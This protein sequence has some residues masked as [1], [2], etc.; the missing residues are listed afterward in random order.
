MKSTPVVLIVLT[1]LFLASAAAQ[2]QPS[3]LLWEIGKSDNNNAEFALA[4]NGY[5]RFA[6]GGFFVVGSSDSKLDWPYVHPGPADRLWS[7]AD[8]HT[9]L[10]VFGLKSVPQDGQCKLRLD[11]LDTHKLDPPTMRIEINGKRFEHKMPPGTGDPTVFGD[12]K[13]GKEHKFDVNFPAGLLRPGNNEIALTLAAGS[14][15]LYDWIGLEA[16]A[17]AELGEV[18]GGTVVYNMRSAPGLIE[19]DGKL[20]QALRLSVRHAGSKCHGQLC[21]DGQ[22]VADVELSGG[23]RDVEAY[24]PA[25]EKPTPV[26]VAL[27]ADGKE[28]YSQK[29]ELRPVR[30]WVVHLL[31]HSHVDIGYTMIQTDVEK[32]Q[33]NHIDAALDLAKKSAAFGKDAQFKWNCEVLW[34]VESYLRTRPPE[35]QAAFIQAVK[36]GHLGLDAL[37]G[38]ELTGL[39]RPEELI[40]LVRYSQDLGK[41]C[42]VKVDSAMISDVPG[43]TWGLVSAFSQAGVRYFSDGVNY[44]DRIG[45]AL[46]VW[47]DK[48]F[49]WVG[50]DGKSKVLF[51]TPYM[52]YALGHTGYRLDPQILDRLSELE[53]KGYPY[54]IV[55]MRWNVGGDNG[56]PDAGLAQVVKNFNARFAYPKLRIMTT[57]NSFREFEAK[58]GDKLPEF[59]GDFTPYWEDGAASSARETA[60]NREAAEQ[61]SQAETLFALRNPAAYPAKDFYEAWRNIVLYDEHT[62]GAHNSI[63]QPDSPF[64]KAQWKIKGGF[65]TDAEAQSENLLESA[66]PSQPAG[67]ARTAIDVWNTSAWPRTDLVALTLNLDG[68]EDLYDEAGVRVPIQEIGVVRVAL[69]RNV[70]PFAA[71]RLTFGKPKAEQALPQ[72]VK[73][74]ATGISCGD[75]SLRIDPANGAIASLKFGDKELVDTTAGTGLNE[76]FYVQNVDVAKPQKVTKVTVTVRSAGPLQGEL[77]IESEAPGCKKLTRHL[78][79]TAGLDRVDVT[80]RVDKLPIRQKE[81]VHFG[82]PFLVPGGQMRLDTPFA[83]VRPELDQIPGSC[84]NWFTIQRWADVSNA[85]FG[86]TW[87]NVDAPMLEVGGL[88]ADKLG[89]QTNPAVW[90][91]KLAPTQKLYSYVMN[92]YWHTNY[93]ADQDGPHTFRYSIRP[94]K[95]G[96]D[97]VAAQRFGV[98]M[99]QPLLAVPAAGDPAAN[100]KPRL[101][102]DGA[103]VIVTAFKPSDDGKG[104]I[105]RLFNTTGQPT[106]ATVKWADP[107]PKAVCLSNA[108]EDA[109]GPAG[110]TIEI[111]PMGLVTLRAER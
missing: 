22:A 4:P 3:K 89:S 77:V 63:H 33:M 40:R 47:Q 100:A 17:S 45:G 6:G 66:L 70:P 11:L 92:N 36:D 105:V 68:R 9:F 99:S 109:C 65:A 93:K 95:G 69:V 60:L 7:K 52:G 87:A 14:W 31:P 24:V 96:Y 49:W 43:V 53:R 61:L 8:T 78:R 90:I 97:A 56:P 104:W 94:H 98:E 21:I 18:K 19:K 71:K 30:R 64:V 5:A 38:N 26:Q 83:V 48:P 35:K 20:M 79:M 80:D 15:I 39:C 103:G 50:P 101:T 85:D 75:I 84:K 86:V 34:A 73:A 42:G 16:P 102:V 28:I 67:Q 88:T 32:R 44:L 72:V 74:D 107:A 51:W 82:F 29:Q 1:G 23:L 76:Y 58:F 46:A 12:P 10:I 91:Q 55:Q 13:A 111:G 108:A 2:A 62:W 54:D 57:S 106:K 110:E 81:G 59:R 41:R 27:T 25:V 37:Y